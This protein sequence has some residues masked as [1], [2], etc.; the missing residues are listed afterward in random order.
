MKLSSND[1]T[2]SNYV[3]KYVNLTVDGVRKKYYVEST[4]KFSSLTGS[5]FLDP[6]KYVYTDL[7]LSSKQYCEKACIT[8]GLNIK[9]IY[10][11]NE[12]Y[13]GRK[14]TCYG[15]H[16]CNDA[17]F[18]FY[19]NEVLLGLVNLNNNNDGGS[20]E[21]SFTLSSSQAENI[22]SVNNKIITFRLEC[23]K[24]G[25]CH[26]TVPW[27]LITS[28]DNEVIYDDCPSTTKFDVNIICT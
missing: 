21:A 9:V 11:K 13:K 4:T 28:P 22:A 20:R 12:T 19:A 10:S 5:T 27:V 18:N 6:S 14:A 15:G 2:F 7:Q 17:L 16:K 1:P 3:G 24:P 8:E 26:D 23:A 25:R